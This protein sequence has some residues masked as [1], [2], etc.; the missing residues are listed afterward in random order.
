MKN[1]LF[2][3]TL[4]SYCSCP[5]LLWAQGENNVWCFGRRAGIDFNNGNPVFFEHSM[6][7]SEASVSVSDAAGNL[8]FYTCGAR[9]WDK[10][11]TP[12]PNATALAGSTGS[13][14]NGVV[15][16][17]SPTNPDQY[18]IFTTD[19]IES[20]MDNAYYSVVD[21]SLNGGLG[22]AIPAQ[23]SILITTGVTE[24]VAIAPLS[25]CRGYWIMF[26]R[27]SSPDYL[28]YRF[29]AA[30]VAGSPVVSA[31]PFLTNGGYIKFNNAGNRIVT[32]KNTRIETASF[33]N[34]TGVLSGFAEIDITPHTVSFGLFSPDDQKVYFSAQL[35]PL[36]DTALYQLDISLLP[37]VAAVQSSLTVVARIKS[38][39]MRQGPDNKIYVLWAA[40]GHVAR[41]NNP[42]V[43]GLACDV[44]TAFMPLP[45]Y[46]TFGPNGPAL[47]Y[48]L[49][50]PV[51]TPLLDTLTSIKDTIICFQDNVT[52]QATAGYSFYRWNTGGDNRTKN[53]SEEGLYWVSGRK[54][55]S[56][57][58]DSFR[59]HFNRFSVDLGPDTFICSDQT[60]TLDAKIADATYLWQDGSTGATYP[61]RQAGVYSVAVSREQCTAYDTVIIEQISPQISIQEPDTTICEG[62]S[63]TLHVVA[64]PA[65]QFLWN[66]GS[67][68]DHIIVDKTGTYT[69][70]GTSVCG[71]L[72]DEVVVTSVTC[73]CDNPFVPNA[74][75]PNGDGKNET[76][77]ARLN[78]P[79]LNFR[80][81]IYNRYGQRI[82]ES[83]DPDTGWDGLQQGNKAD[84]GTYFYLLRYKTNEGKEI[85]KKGDVTLLR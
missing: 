15:V 41:I 20:G 66:T 25:D 21:M 17:Q 44:D 43:A 69:I 81:S 38:R 46:A 73:N 32:P 23:S 83:T 3:I 27:K 78:C 62:T 24:G 9:V 7:I 37:N 77:N 49:G 6:N 39:G 4:L 5:V 18:Y 2:L 22:D 10:N 31:T 72:K 47:F 67:T 45:A 52:L 80:F 74:F 35:S 85:Q 76:L 75:S 33:N 79:S 42:N 29:D 30:G 13:S 68:A 64:T 65:S 51:I 60:K 1:C 53:F 14:S 70:T 8:L 34:S 82:F 63:V 48:E 36:S 58:I 71:T 55:C 40:R 56:F 16:A 11:G 61:V 84:I 12:M 59:L 19:Q 26:H 54:D 28:A 57:H 50:T